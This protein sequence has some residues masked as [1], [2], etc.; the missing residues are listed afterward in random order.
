MAKVNGTL[1]AIYHDSDR[2]LYATGA[3]LTTDQN[4]ADVTTK[5]SG[6]NAGHI[7]GIRKWSIDFAGRYDEDDTPVGITA[8]D[9]MALIIAGGTAADIRFEASDGSIDKMWMGS[10]TIQNMKILKNTSQPMDYSGSIQGTGELMNWSFYWATQFDTWQ[11]AGSDVYVFGQP[12]SKWVRQGYSPAGVDVPMGGGGLVNG[13]VVLNKGQAVRQKGYINS[14]TL[15]V[16][17]NYPVG[18]NWQFELYYWNG[19][20]YQCKA[21]QPFMPVPDNASPDDNQTFVLASPI[22]A[23]EGDIPAIYMP[24]N[25]GGSS[26]ADIP[27]TGAGREFPFQRRNDGGDIAVGGSHAFTHDANSLDPTFKFLCLTGFGNR[28]YAVF[29]GDSIIGGGNNYVVGGDERNWRTDQEAYDGY[30]MPGGSP[31]D[32]NLSIP[33]RL[34][35]R[36][37]SNFRYQNFGASGFHFYDII[38][39]PGTLERAL[40]ADPKAVFIH[41]GI[42]DVFAGQSWVQVEAN[43]DTLRIALP[44]GTVVY[45]DEILPW[46]GTDAQALTTRTFNTNYA[47]YCI[48]HGWTLIEC[49]DLMGV[50]RPSTGELDDLNPL[51]TVD[52]VHTNDVGADAMADIIAT[53]FNL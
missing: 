35:T 42:N 1:F 39:S 16:M 47:A 32:Q 19:T 50:V 48:T 3:T 5:E 20:A 33:H 8:D 14:F 43:L 7:R 41:C 46:S 51:Y 34:S 29:L 9:V 10:G 18:T 30:H 11:N 45:L 24:V 36:M 49:H 22:L 21:K 6:G 12:V 15:H 44:T 17:W 27:L 23:E 31:G 53:Y 40:L 4:L 37:P 26:S 52:G 2:I 38:A 25:C 28:P 13:C